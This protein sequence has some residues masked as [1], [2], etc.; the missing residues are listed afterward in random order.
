MKISKSRLIEIIK[1]EIENFNENLLKEFVSTA[2]AA[3]AKKGGYESPTTRSKQDTYDTKLATKNTRQGTYND[4]KSALNAL[5]SKKFRK[6]N[7]RARDGYDYSAT[8]I[9]G[10]EL[11]PDWIAK[12][13][14]NTLALTAKNTA[15]T[16]SDIALSDLETS[17][18]ADLLAQVPK[19]RQPAAA[20][21]MAAFGKGKSAGKAGKGRGKGKAKKKK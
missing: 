6:A 8:E 7:P 2:T 19:E 1:E 16:E 13:A 15:D 20:A 9:R 10:G 11:N 18:A 12:D 21:G 5:I 14:A 3:G 17:Q 4:K